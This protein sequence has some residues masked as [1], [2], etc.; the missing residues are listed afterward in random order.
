M[1]YEILVTA[2]VLIGLL[3][4]PSTAAPGISKRWS[5]TSAQS[6]AC[7]RIHAGKF[8]TYPTTYLTNLQFQ[9]CY[10]RTQ[11]LGSGGANIVEVMNWLDKSHNSEFK[12]QTFTLKATIANRCQQI[13]CI[14]QYATYSVCDN[15]P[16]PKTHSWTGLELTDIIE[17]F[18]DLTWPVG[19]WVDVQSKQIPKPRVISDTDTQWAQGQINK[20][21]TMWSCCTDSTKSNRQPLVSDRFLGTATSPSDNTRF[22]IA[23][24][25]SK[26]CDPSKNAVGK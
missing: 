5:L 26:V 18:W 3:I 25:G 24:S 19:S 9:C 20:G 15:N 7:S 21:A 4:A 10:S 6:T 2:V 23:A 16:I 11:T 13:S 22:V 8:T 17:R 14:G 12:Q 1:L